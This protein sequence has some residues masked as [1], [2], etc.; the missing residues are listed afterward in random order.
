MRV[1]LKLFREKKYSSRKIARTLSTRAYNHVVMKA[2]RPILRKHHFLIK[3]TL[4]ETQERFGL[5]IR[6][7]AIMPDH[8]HLVVQVPSRA[9]F[10]NA[11]RFLAGMIALRIG[12]GKL[13]RARC[14]SRIVRE[15]RDLWNATTY[16][17]RNSIKAGIIDERDTAWIQNGMLVTD[18]G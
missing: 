2:G 15:G 3:K 4:R 10:A 5:R 18:Y 12:K 8:V 7:I 1:Q 14:W 11:M 13:W 16:V 6:A 17:W 9:L